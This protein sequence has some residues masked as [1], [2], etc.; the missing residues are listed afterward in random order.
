MS[1]D[2]HEA[3][4]FD[5]LKQTAFLTAFATLGNVTRAA[6]AAGCSRRVH[7][8]WLRFDPSYRN[9]FLHARREACN[10]LESEARRRAVAGVPEVQLYRGKPVFVYVD[11]AGNICDVD[12]RTADPSKHS[13]VPLMVRKYSDKL[14]ALLLRA[15]LPKKYGSRQHDT[16][17]PPSTF[18][19]RAELVEEVKEW[20]E[21]KRAQGLLPPP[22]EPTQ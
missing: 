18:K 13:K 9:R 11:A 4:R 10:A 8:N 22:A 3:Q 16:L 5:T 6:E 7:S 15:N 1:E 12:A 14:L 2:S 19:T 20:L 21:Q 17:A